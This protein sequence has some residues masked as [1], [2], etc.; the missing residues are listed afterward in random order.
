MSADDAHAS[1][2]DAR[3]GADRVYVT[4]LGCV[5]PLGFGAD[6]LAGAFWSGP[7]DIAASGTERDEQHT[8]CRVPE[9][10]MGDFIETT[11]P[12]LDTHSR[13]SLAAVSLALASAGIESDELDPARSGLASATVFG[14]V[15]SQEKFHHLV[16]E[17][18]VRL[19]SPV[20][21]PHCYPNTT[22]S[23]LAIEFG[24]RG[25]NQ[26][27]C[28]DCVCGAKSVQI[29]DAALRDGL[30]DMMA[31]GG[32]DALTDALIERLSQGTP[33]SDSLLPGEGASYLVLESRDAIRAREA[34]PICELAC[35]ISRGTGVVGPPSDAD[36]GRI[37]KAIL[38]TVHEALR[39][40]GLWEG[41]LGAVFLTDPCD[42]DSLRPR[43]VKQALSSFSQLPTFT[44]LAAMG[45]TF[46]AAFPF[47]CMSAALVLHQ[48]ALP[49]PPRLEKV[50]KGVEL[51]IEQTPAGLLGNA[52]LVLGWSSRHV[53]AAVLKA[54]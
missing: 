14:N 12:Y 49:S 50:H 31:V 1:S 51:W 38:D 34:V 48:G 28:G 9:L 11:R 19:A 30:A 2:D 18:G 6:A 53:V 3:R 4:G 15:G 36:E 26:N 8:A 39:E 5:C 7:D 16:R 22:N 21:F 17:K 29:G 32:C 13:F 24:L 37:A 35:V 20:L 40:V 54:I 45:Q 46:A 33:E 25:Y 47:Q 41:D 23:L 10:E 42:G 52:A 27:V 43:A 44:P